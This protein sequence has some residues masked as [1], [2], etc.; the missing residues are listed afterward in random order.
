MNEYLKLVEEAQKKRL[1]LTRKQTYRIRNLYRD[2]AR[3]LEKR[4]KQAPKNSL[5][6]RWLMDYQRQFKSSIKYLNKALL[7]D[8][9]KSMLASAEYAAGIQVDLF[10]FI[11]TKYKLDA[12]ETFSN[13]FSK[14][15]QNALQELIS[16][17]FYKDGKGLNERVWFNEK[18]TNAEF[19]YILQKGLLEKKSIYELANDL[20]SYVNPKVQND[21]Q[22]KKIYP[23]V[24][25]K[26]IE[27]NSFRLAVT[28]ISH[29]YQLSLKKSCKANPFV[30]KIE[31]HTSNSHRG[32]CEVCRSRE[33]KKYNPDEL[34]LDHPN[35]ICYFTPVIDKTLDEIGSELHDWLH[36][37]SNSKLDNWFNDYGKEFL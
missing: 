11:N 4:I 37:G 36:G 14:I 9:Q 19:D 21:W 1:D 30:D 10:D 15:S 34:P 8:L 18:K 7:N 17:G 32:P 33:G 35:G 27:Y 22:F 25:N 13:M 5:N 16:G 26:K 20:A 28:S 2:I 31:W 29:A 6:E 3:D 12:K 23:G 24:G